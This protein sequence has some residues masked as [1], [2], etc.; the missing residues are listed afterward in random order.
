[1]FNR[2]IIAGGIGRDPEVRFTKSGIAVVNLSVAVGE[3]RK[4]DGE[5]SEVT[6]W[7][8]VTV[9][10]KAAENCGQFLKKGSKVLIEGR[11]ENQKFTGKDGSERTKFVVIA[12]NVRF[13][14]GKPKD[15]GGFAEG[16]AT[17]GD[18][19]LPF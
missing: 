13:L 4:V 18:D 1:M 15:G 19:D 16:S 3:R 9:F 8:D 6:T 10:G 2:V 11:G 14:S 7:F 12:D 5:Y 17:G